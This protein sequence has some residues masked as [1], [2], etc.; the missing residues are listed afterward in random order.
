MANFVHLKQDHQTQRR[1]SA[2]RFQNNYTRITYQ[3][4]A[5]CDCRFSTHW[6]IFAFYSFYHGTVLL[7]CATHPAIL[8]PTRWPPWQFLRSWQGQ[9]WR[10]HHSRTGDA[11]LTL[12]AW[13]YFH[14]AALHE[15]TTV[16]FAATSTRNFLVWLPFFFL[17][18]LF[19]CCLLAANVHKRHKGRCK[20]LTSAHNV[21]Y[22][23]V[24]CKYMYA[25]Y[26]ISV[27]VTYTYY[28]PWPSC[29]HID[30]EHVSNNE[31]WKTN[32]VQTKF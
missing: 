12:L 22:L 7:C 9:E 3:E 11:P 10:H 6:Y 17:L 14:D 27:L 1:P 20:S 23:Y 25:Y 16:D 19:L 5:W 18:V 32:H 29:A 13:R 26:Y 24:Y 15:D 21:S 28:H 8:R 31:K 30:A 4:G 2:L